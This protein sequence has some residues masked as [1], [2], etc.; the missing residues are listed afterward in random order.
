MA[1]FLDVIFGDGY[2]PDS[3]EVAC[4]RLLPWKYPYK[5]KVLE[6]SQLM[7]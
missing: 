2:M 1:I 5:A 7:I 4:F 6:Y 3:Q